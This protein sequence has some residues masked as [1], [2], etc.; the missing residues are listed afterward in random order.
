MLLFV[1]MQKEVALT[2]QEKELAQQTA[3]ENLAAALR[4]MPHP[5]LRIKDT[6]HHLYCKEGRLR[7]LVEGAYQLRNRA[8]AEPR[9]TTILSVT[10]VRNHPV[11]CVVL[12]GVS[13]PSV[14]RRDG[15]DAPSLTDGVAVDSDVHSTVTHSGRG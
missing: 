11:V 5:P 13:K 14:L 10:S 3:M 2:D 1:R 8:S 6:D 9:C 7:E 15:D 12:S 4:S